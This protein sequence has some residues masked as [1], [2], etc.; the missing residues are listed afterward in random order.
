MPTRA[1]AVTIPMMLSLAA[2]CTGESDVELLDLGP[3]GKADGTGAVLP[4]CVARDSLFATVFTATLPVV[5]RGTVPARYYA[6]HRN[7]ADRAMLL[8][9]PE[10]FPRMRQLIG[11]AEHEVDLQ[12]YVWENDS[13]PARDIFAG[14]RDL[15]ATARAEGRETPVSVRILID[16]FNEGSPF[17]YPGKYRITN[18]M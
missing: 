17:A 10:I 6:T 9:G 15:E 3:D 7:H 11:E 14:L 13:D 12:F 4:T 16:A 2:A 18:L 5:E 1:A 8:R